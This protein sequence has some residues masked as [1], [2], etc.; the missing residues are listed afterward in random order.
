RISL[1]AFQISTGSARSP[2]PVTNCELSFL[3]GMAIITPQQTAARTRTLTLG[4][5]RRVR[6]CANDKLARR[7]SNN[8]GEAKAK[9]WRASLQAVA[10]LKSKG[11]LYEKKSCFGFGCR[12][13]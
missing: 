11:A 12:C 13:R 2:L 10:N 3:S 7:H 6:F 8:F 9:E 1:R 5:Q 4:W